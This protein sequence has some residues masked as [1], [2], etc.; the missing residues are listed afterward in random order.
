MQYPR[1]P[2]EFK[3]IILFK[4]WSLITFFAFEVPLVL[5]LIFVV[6]IYLYI[7]DKMN[8]YYHYRMETIDNEVEFNFLK[9]YS[10]VFSVYLFITFIVTQYNE[11]EMIIGGAAMVIAILVQTFYFRRLRDN[12][13]SSRDS[14]ITLNLDDL[15]EVDSYQARY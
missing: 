12:E 8:I 7:K 14:F 9:I 4:F 1:F 3:L 10:N 6:L 5:F 13:P 15:E 11:Y 2:I